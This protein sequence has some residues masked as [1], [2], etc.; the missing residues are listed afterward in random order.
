MAGNGVRALAGR[1]CSMACGA[2]CPGS[3]VRRNSGTDMRIAAYARYS[4]DHQRDASLDDQL[5]NCRAY[6]ARMGWPDP[7]A[8]SDKAISGVRNDRPGYCQLLADVSEGRFEVLLVDDLS[9]LSRDAEECQRLLKRFNFH[10]VR[11]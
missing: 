11:L 2:R 10:G 9:R 8:Y 4:S 3:Q 1:G 5:R 7:V 6:A